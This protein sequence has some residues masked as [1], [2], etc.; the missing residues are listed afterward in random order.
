[1]EA[2]LTADPA[3]TPS[4][5]LKAPLPEV[6]V[7]PVLGGAATEAAIDAILDRGTTWSRNE[8]RTPT[9]GNRE[10][11][12]VSLGDPSGKL[13]PIEETNAWNSVLA[14]D[15]A[16]AQTFLYVMARCL[17]AADEPPARVRVHVNDILAFR[18]VKR[19][20]S[21]DYKVSQKVEERERVLL[22]NR[23][24]V[25]GRD[26]V[27]EKRGK[28]IRK[29][30]VRLYSRLI[31][32]QIE[33]DDNLG[34]LELPNIDLASEVVPYA[35]RV[36][37]GGW[38]N[39]YRGAQLYVRALLDRIVKYDPKRTVERIALRVGLHLHF[40]P[41][42]SLSVRNLLDGGKIELPE[43]NASRFRDAVEEALDLLVTDGVLGDWSYGSTTELP[44]HGWAEKWL[45]WIIDIKP[46]NI[47]LQAKIR[48]TARSQ[49]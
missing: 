40:R 35:F 24:W 18:G 36:G 5:R 25:A 49:S 21:G 9:Y 47:A 2:A 6:A 14:L 23:M 17:A 28:T 7:L 41:A 3:K 43:R 31:E 4:R 26:V 1:M 48:T 16:T 46:P 8:A 39:T 29:K 20:R 22:L 12:Y 11:T 34:A 32:L 15:D 38:N 44:G 42:P 37:L 30:R 10:E 13:S 19:H 45:D 33:A 27:E